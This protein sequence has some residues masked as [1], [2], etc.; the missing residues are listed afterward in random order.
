MDMALGWRHDIE[1]R[2]WLRA[3]ARVFDPRL[4]SI[5]DAPEE[6]DPRQALMPAWMQAAIGSCAGN[7]LARCQQTLNWTETQGGIVIPSRM[8]AYFLGQR[9]CGTFGKDE[10]AT[11][12]AVVKGAMAYGN[13]L[14]SDFPYPD[15]YEEGMRRIQDAAISGRVMRAANGHKLLAHTVLRTYD[16]CFRFLAGGHGVIIIGIPW[17][18]SHA[19]NRT[20]VIDE[21]C[22][23]NLG[24]HAQAICGWTRRKDSSGRKYLVDFNSHGDEWGNHGTAEI[25][26]ALFDQ[27]G[28]DGF[29]EMIGV[30]RQQVFGPNDAGRLNWLKGGVF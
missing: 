28:Q 4:V 17:V 16:E 27:W 15:S 22:G 1:D 9:L 20:G 21:A 25:T 24:G 29:S 3:Y 11:I 6:M 10:G 30:G 13:C 23:R 26:P 7:A 19:R 12:A 8:L 2:R 5:A 14:E 18:E